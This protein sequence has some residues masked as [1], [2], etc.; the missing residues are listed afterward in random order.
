MCKAVEK[1]NRFGANAPRARLR[2]VFENLQLNKNIAAA[3]GAW[4]VLLADNSRDDMSGASQKRH[5]A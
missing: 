3:R 1:V 4:R 2:Q 5:G